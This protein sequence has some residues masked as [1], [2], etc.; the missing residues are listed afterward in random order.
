MRL[1]ILEVKKLALRDSDSVRD[2]A[3]KAKF[4]TDIQAMDVEAMQKRLWLHDE[5]LR[6]VESQIQK[7]DLKHQSAYEKLLRFYES[8]DHESRVTL[9][10]DWPRPF[11]Q[12]RT[13]QESQECFRKGTEKVMWLS[14]RI[15]VQREQQMRSASLQRT[16]PCS[17]SPLRITP[18]ELDS[19]KSVELPRTKE[20]VEVIPTDLI[21]WSAAPTKVGTEGREGFLSRNQCA[22]VVREI[23][24]ESTDGALWTCKRC[25]PSSTRKG[26]HADHCW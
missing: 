9:R 15:A 14:S 25:C 17:P 6:Q 22:L 16:R 18:V 13:K 26:S 7:N 24:V 11:Q 20:S 19:I 2:L 4:Q 1:E 10:T 5:Q 12:K 3:T 23:K 21:T 8:Y